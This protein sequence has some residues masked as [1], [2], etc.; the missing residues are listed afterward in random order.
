MGLSDALLLSSVK[1]SPKS[2]LTKVYGMWYDMAPL[3][4]HNLTHV[5]PRAVKIVLI[6]C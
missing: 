2:M 5:S 4:H 1:S 3:G 6:H